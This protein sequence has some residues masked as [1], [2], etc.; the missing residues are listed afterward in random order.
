MPLA[1]PTTFTPAPTPI[2]FLLHIPRGTVKVAL[3]VL[4]FATLAFFALTRTEVGR[5]GVRQ[6]IEARFRS[7]YAGS[8]QIGDLSGN[9]VYSFVASNVSL[10]DPDGRLIGHIDTVRAEPSWEP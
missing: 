4:F 1:G 2:R 5:E 7:T 3:Y 8:I 6:E 10:F 9:L